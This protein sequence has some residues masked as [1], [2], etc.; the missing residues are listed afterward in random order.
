MALIGLVNTCHWELKRLKDVV[1]IYSGYGFLDA[2]GDLNGTIPFYKV[3]DINGSEKYLK[4]SNNSV[5][6]KTC[7]EN[8]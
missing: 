2:Q 3:S 1:N 8:G 4:T 6:I 7:R 5:S